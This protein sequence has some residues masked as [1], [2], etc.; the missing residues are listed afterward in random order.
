MDKRGAL[1]TGETILHFLSYFMLVAVIIVTLLT[2]NNV[3]R[4]NQ[5]RI[6]DITGEI[7]KSAFIMNYLRTPIVIN[8][9]NSTM[10]ELIALSYDNPEY[11]AQLKSETEKL[12]NDFYDGIFYFKLEMHDQ[13]NLK[14]VQN[15]LFTPDTIP[16]F[17]TRDPLI[18]ASAE[19]PKIYSSGN[20]YIQANITI[21]AKFVKEGTWC[22]AP[23]RERCH[24]DGKQLCSCDRVGYRLLWQCQSCPVDTKKKLSGDC[25]YERLVCK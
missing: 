6:T 12:I 22:F 24:E 16:I 21:F 2:F 8:N 18:E 15:Y 14:T 13:T 23:W 5:L 4:Q 3:Q 7:E 1:G 17:L 20:T 10:T 25:D 19:V 11:D 9:I